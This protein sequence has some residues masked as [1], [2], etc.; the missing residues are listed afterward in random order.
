MRILSS[1]LGWFRYSKK[2]NCEEKDQPRR[3][4]RSKGHAKDE[5]KSKNSSKRKPKSPPIPMAYFPIGSQLSR[6]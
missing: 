2:I 6:L 1:F 5:E 3:S 4:S